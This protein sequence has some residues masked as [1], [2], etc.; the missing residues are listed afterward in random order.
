ME[1]GTGRLERAVRHFREKR[2]VELHGISDQKNADELVFEW[3]RSWES[4]DHEFSLICTNET[5]G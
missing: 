3:S 2:V 1:R 4:L 5:F